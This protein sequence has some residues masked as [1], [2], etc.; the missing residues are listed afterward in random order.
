M[1]IEQQ[2]IVDVSD[3]VVIIHQWLKQ[4]GK[5]LSSNNTFAHLLLNYAALISRY[6]SNDN[7]VEYVSNDNSVEMIY[8]KH[9]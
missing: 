6:V 3:V 5:D 7:S 2:C 9:Y 4:N 1:H 8:D